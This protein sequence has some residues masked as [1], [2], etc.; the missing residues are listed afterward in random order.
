MNNELDILCGKKRWLLAEMQVKYSNVYL[1]GQITT[2][3][4]IS[5]AD[6]HCWIC[7]VPPEHVANH[8]ITMLDCC[9]SKAVGE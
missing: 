4:S 3:T 1:Q 2:N 6:A 7:Y 9:K 5:L 8:L